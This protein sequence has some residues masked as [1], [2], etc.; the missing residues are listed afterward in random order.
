MGTLKR[1]RWRRASLRAKAFSQL[2]RLKSKFYSIWLLG[3]T[4]SFFQYMY[5]WHF[6]SEFF[7]V[8][9]VMYVVGC[10]A[11]LLLIHWN[12]SSVLVV[13]TKW[14]VNIPDVPPGARKAEYPSWWGH[15]SQRRAAAGPPSIT[16]AS[17]ACFS[18]RQGKE[19]VW[20]NARA[21]DW[22]EKSDYSSQDSHLS[23]QAHVPRC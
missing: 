11:V 9:A 21:R 19:R 8:E 5:Y 17:D 12:V 22:K 16:A 10:F 3:T 14:S 2:T 23:V 4:S 6:E 18:L 13:I 1:A 15:W 7:A 20:K